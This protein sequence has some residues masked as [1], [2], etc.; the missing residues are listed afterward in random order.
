MFLSWYSVP[1]VT[2]HPSVST[3]QLLFCSSQLNQCCH[4]SL[5]AGI[6]TVTADK[7]LKQLLLLLLLLVVVLTAQQ[8]TILMNRCVCLPIEMTS[9]PA[10]CLRLHIITADCFHVN[11]L[12]L[13]T[14]KQKGNLKIRSLCSGFPNR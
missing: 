7:W 12:F 1:N 8:N 6:A 5:K 4:Y 10:P 3:Y 2:T 13:K 9:A 14:G 11:L